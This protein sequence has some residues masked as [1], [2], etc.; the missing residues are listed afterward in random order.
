MGTR[1][2]FGTTYNLEDVTQGTGVDVKNPESLVRA[3]S[4]NNVVLSSLLD[5]FRLIIATHNSLITT[6]TAKNNLLAAYC[7]FLECLVD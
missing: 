2:V 1:K 3:M 7:M 6:A 4:D 5:A